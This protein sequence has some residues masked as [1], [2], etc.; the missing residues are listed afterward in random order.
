MDKIT[1]KLTD[2]DRHRLAEVAKGRYCLEKRSLWMRIRGCRG[3][4]LHCCRQGI[5]DGAIKVS[6]QGGIFS[7]C[8]GLT[9]QGVA[10]FRVTRK[11]L[12]G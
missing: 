10:I 3:I 2:P 11:I 1:C 9:G 12:F 4:G 8:E 5:D 6:S 7:H